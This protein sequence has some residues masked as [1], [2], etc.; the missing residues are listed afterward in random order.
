MRTADY[1]LSALADI[2]VGR[3]RLTIEAPTVFLDAIEELTRVL[4]TAPGGGD[5]VHIASWY[6]HER[7]SALAQFVDA[8]CSGLPSVADELEAG[9]IGDM[10]VVDRSRGEMAVARSEKDLLWRVS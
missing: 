4:I 1:V 3:A 6:T 9:W 5:S 7:T 10:R 2:R 8:A